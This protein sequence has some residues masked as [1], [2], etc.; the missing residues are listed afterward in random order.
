MSSYYRIEVRKLKGFN[1]QIKFS[2]FLISNL[3]YIVSY[4]D[5]GMFQFQTHASH[6]KSAE[7]WCTRN[8]NTQSTWVSGCYT[9]LLLAGEVTL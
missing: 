4:A 2:L 5:I 9:V 6:A 3:F 8:W 1:L 7:S